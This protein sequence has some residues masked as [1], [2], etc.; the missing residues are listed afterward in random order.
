MI[1]DDDVLRDVILELRNND[2][3]PT[4]FKYTAEFID[5]SNNI[6]PVYNVVSLTRTAN[7]LKDYTDY[8]FITLQVSQTVKLRLLDLNRDRIRLRLNKIPNSTSGTT[9]KT[10]ITQT[11]ELNAFLNDTT[12]ESIENKIGGFTGNRI[13]NLGNLIQI[14]VQLVEKGISEFKYTSAFGVYPNN[15]PGNVIKGLLMHP[16]KALSDGEDKGYDVH[17]EPPHNDTIMYQIVIPSNISLIDVPKYMQDTYGIYGSGMGYY[18]SQKMW[19]VYPLYDFGRFDKTKSRMT[20]INIPRNE[21]MGIDN[22]YTFNDGHLIVYATG[23]TK[24]IDTSS[25]GIE[26]DG[27]GV[28]FAKLGNL[29]DNHSVSTKGVTAIPEG[30]NVVNIG[31]GVREEKVAK[32]KMVDGMHSDNIWKDTSKILANMGHNVI[33]TWEASNHNLLYPGMPVRLIYKHRG[34]TSLETR[35]IS[36]TLIAADSH[37]GT[38]QNSVTDNRYIGATVLNIFVERDEDIRAPIPQ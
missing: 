23:D 1:I 32:I 31:L 10:G 4:N 15:T 22:S 2:I 3:N 29:I 6:I 25:A 21:M 5:E 28:R 37:S 34:R 7:Y 20:I 14:T 36:G 30:R 9:T 35:S 26:R 19:Y 38:N 13:D 12:S 18:L 27:V 24:L 8:F 16:L 11:E 33:L 17:M